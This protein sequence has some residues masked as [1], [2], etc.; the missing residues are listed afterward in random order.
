MKQVLNSTKKNN[1]FFVRSLTGLLFVSLIIAAVIIHPYAYAALALL[2]SGIA[3][4]ELARMFLSQE[5]ILFQ[6]LRI[7]ISTA[8]F[9]V[10]STMF[11][12]IKIPYAEILLLILLALIFALGFFTKRK[13]TLTSFF[14][15]F[16][17]VVPFVLSISF[18]LESKQ[19]IDL[20][21]SSE[22]LLSIFVLI[23][24]SDSFAYI[25]GSLFGKHKIYPAISP[26][27]SWEGFFGGAILTFVVAVLFAYF[28]SRSISTY[29]VLS[30][31]VVI[32]G[33]IGDFLESI[34]KRKCNIKDSSS[35]L[36]G[37][38]GILDRFDSFLLI[39]PIL[40]CLNLI[41]NLF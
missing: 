33:T 39:I 23:W 12:P 8:F 26:K 27:K 38:G 30:F 24:I 10:L 29:I 17:V 1:V 3:V 28:F 16:Y 19:N 13:N 34:L 6:A 7:F 14:A 20:L 35:I 5:K 31:I 40:F 4:W 18:L 32:F 15:L 11:L 9:I 2:F 25:F 41:F 36:P 22:F 37:H 21:H